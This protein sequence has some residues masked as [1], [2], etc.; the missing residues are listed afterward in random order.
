[1]FFLLRM[2]FWLGL[3]LLIL[4]I[5]TSHDGTRQIGAW[6][7]LAAAQSVVSDLRGFCQRQPD[8]CALGGEMASNVLDKAQVGAKWLYDTFGA[9]ASSEH[10]PSNTHTGGALTPQDLPSAGSADPSP[11]PVSDPGA[12]APVM[13]PLPPRRPT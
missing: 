8:A 4:P 11:A 13:I 2:A 1:M 6:Q 10:A 7:A 12:A 9:K 3:I 5:G